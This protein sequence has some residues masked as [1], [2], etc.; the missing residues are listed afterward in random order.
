[1]S[2]QHLGSIFRY[3][4]HEEAFRRNGY[5]IVDL[6]QSADL[7]WLRSVFQRFRRYH[8]AGFSATLLAKDLGYRRAIHGELSPKVAAKLQT[9]LHDYKPICCGFACKGPDA[10]GGEMP[11]HQDITMVQPGGRA[12]LTL[13]APLFDVDPR[14]GCLEV[15]PTSHRFDSGPRAPGT[16]FIGRA[17]EAEIRSQYLDPLPLAAG[18]AIFLHGATI[19]ASG[20]N[21]SRSW[22]PVL[23]VPLA[24]RE[25]DLV[26]Y[27]RGS[28]RELESFTVSDEFYLEH[29]IGSRPRKAQR[30]GLVAEQISPLTLAALQAPQRGDLP[31]GCSS[32]S[33]P[34]RFP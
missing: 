27:H 13:W 17:C 32:L 26:Y 25:A 10:T 11:L 2:H 14:N 16:P 12:G 7:E 30:L 34:R 4:P 23:A 9:V 24:P 1:M 5:V 21:R 8:S 15:V 6:W 29:P 18:Q 31:K 3:A 28:R 33:P 20:K 22:R 19:H